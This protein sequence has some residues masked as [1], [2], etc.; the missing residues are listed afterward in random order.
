VLDLLDLVMQCH[1]G[2]PLDFGHAGD[3]PHALALLV[4]AAFDDVM[5]QQE[6][7]LGSNGDPAQRA[8]LLEVWRAHV[9][10]RFV[11]ST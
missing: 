3:P 4:A 5:T 9:W 1:L 11:V 7:A 2:Q 8:G 10:L 6:W